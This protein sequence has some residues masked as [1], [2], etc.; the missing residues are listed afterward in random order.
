MPDYTVLQP[1]PHAERSLQ[2]GA[3]VTLSPR[4]AKYLLLS[5]KI[6]PFV[7]AKPVRKTKPAEKE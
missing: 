6:A 7:A 1:L 3:V 2:P 5:R 4:Q